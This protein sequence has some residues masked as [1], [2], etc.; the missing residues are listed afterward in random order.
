MISRKLKDYFYKS[1]VLLSTIKPVHDKEIILVIVSF[2]KLAKIRA[3]YKIMGH[4]F[5]AKTFPQSLQKRP[6][7]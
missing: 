3:F 6:L 5:I 1:D 2:K 7:C 4:H